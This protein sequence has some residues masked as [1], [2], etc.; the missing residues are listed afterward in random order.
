MKDEYKLYNIEDINKYDKFFSMF[1]NKLSIE[2]IL[3]VLP[4]FYKKEFIKDLEICDYKP[5]PKRCLINRAPP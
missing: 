2:V 3:E 4:E 1:S 5:F